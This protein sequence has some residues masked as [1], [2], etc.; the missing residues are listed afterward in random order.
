MFNLMNFC[1]LWPFILC[2]LGC[3]A[4]VKHFHYLKGEGTFSIIEFNGIYLNLSPINAI[5]V[6]VACNFEFLH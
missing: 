5:I 4:R 6:S 2:A 3:M 1:F